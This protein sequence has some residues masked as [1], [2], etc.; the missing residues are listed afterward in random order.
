MPNSDDPDWL[1]RTEHD[2]VAIGVLVD[3][4]DGVVATC[5][6]EGIPYEGPANV[7]RGFIG[8]RVKDPM[9]NNVNLLQWPR[10]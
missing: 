10:R 7:Y 4:I 5:E 3:S 9:G 2:A 8:V 1:G 6:A